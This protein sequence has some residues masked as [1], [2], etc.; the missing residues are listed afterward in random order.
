MNTLLIE[1]LGS[2]MRGRST[3]RHACALM[4]S[5][6]YADCTLNS[7]LWKQLVQR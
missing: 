2:P 7:A 3:V 4:F 6:I 1:N 5:G